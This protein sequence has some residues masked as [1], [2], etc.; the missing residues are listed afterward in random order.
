MTCRRVRTEARAHT[1]CRGHHT[2]ADRG[3][4]PDLPDAETLSAPGCGAVLFLASEEAGHVNGTTLVVAGGASVP[5]PSSRAANHTDER[6][7]KRIVP[8]T[9]ATSAS[10][11]VARRVVAPWTDLERRE[12]RVSEHAP[13]KFG[14]TKSWGDQL[15]VVTDWAGATSGHG[16]RGPNRAGLRSDLRWRRRQCQPA[17]MRGP[18]VLREPCV[19]VVPLGPRRRLAQSISIGLSG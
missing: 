8:G 3:A 18:T 10:V 15:S 1:C 5:V 7:C 13:A 17:D 16:G 4:A 12:C 14:A 19:E 11:R 6:G 2:G 9:A